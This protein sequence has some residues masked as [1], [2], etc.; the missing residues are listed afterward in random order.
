MIQISPGVVTT[1]TLDRPAVK[2]ALD[3]TTIDALHCALDAAEAT[4]RV[5]VL[6][7]AGDEVFCAGAD[8]AQVAGNPEG[9][10]AAAQ[11][12]ARL[13][14]RLSGYER[15][16]IARV[17]GHVLAGGVGLLLACDLAVVADDTTI[18]LP[19]AAVG[20]WPMMVGAFL[21]REL[22]R[23]VALEMA[24]TGR[25]LSAAEAVT[26][27]IVNHAVPRGDLDTAIT[28][29][30][31]AVTARSPSALRL[32]RRAW[33]D[34]TAVPLDETLTLLAERLCDVMETED[35]AEGFAAFL[36][37]RTPLWSDR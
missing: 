7:G 8:L 17:N 11:A 3:L 27:G 36:Q 22:P 9:R 21:L 28:A 31:N 26:W 32:G 16:V 14:S 29:L 20:M 25:K 33:R 30:A 4:A 2:N 10:R 24:L 12:Y 13:L 19:E 5:I 37:K 34:A 23:K 15:P 35:A 6:T 18:A 1:L